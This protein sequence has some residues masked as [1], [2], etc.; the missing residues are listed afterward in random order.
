MPENERPRVIEVDFIEAKRVEPER[1]R[2]DPFQILRDEQREALNRIER[3]LQPWAEI[4]VAGSA[5]I[6]A[7]VKV[8]RRAKRAQA[9]RLRGG[10]R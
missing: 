5:L 3:F 6:G 7:G 4:A 9:A 2:V 10:P 1:E 8:Y